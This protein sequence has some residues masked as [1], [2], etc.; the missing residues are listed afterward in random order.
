MLKYSNSKGARNLNNLNGNSDEQNHLHNLFELEDNEYQNP[1]RNLNSGAQSSLGIG[2]NN[3]DESTFELLTQP[4]KKNARE[5]KPYVPRLRNSYIDFV[6]DKED[7]N[8]FESFDNDVNNINGNKTNDKESDKLKLDDKKNDKETDRNNDKSNDNESKNK[9]EKDF[10]NFDNLDFKL[11]DIE[12]DERYGQKLKNDNENYKN[13]IKGNNQ[14]S[15]R[16]DIIPIPKLPKYKP[17]PKPNLESKVI[18]SNKDDSKEIKEVNDDKNLQTSSTT[19]KT[20][21]EYI[22]QPSL[23]PRIKKLRRIRRLRKQRLNRQ[24][25]QPAIDKNLKESIKNDVEQNL[26]DVKALKKADDKSEQV[27]KDEMKKVNVESNKLLKQNQENNQ[28]N[29]PIQIDK[30]IHI[31]ESNPADNKKSNRVIRIVKVIKNKNPNEQE[32][33][34]KVTSVSKTSINSESKDESKNIGVNVPN[35]AIKNTSIKSDPIKN[36][37]KL[38]ITESVNNKL[39]NYSSID[40]YIDEFEDLETKKSRIK[41]VLY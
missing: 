30:T 10:E 8:D 11:D 35:D 32:F 39:A 17:L 21:T 12:N 40:D 31:D 36:N 13:P 2:A 6:K 33:E 28:T 41:H 16:K 29:K 24:N 9:S 34:S 23:E 38:N 4:R 3:L 14:E 15:L 20:P 27:I 5:I 19:S 25:N 7:F 37:T 22:D 1:Y 18:Y 26:K